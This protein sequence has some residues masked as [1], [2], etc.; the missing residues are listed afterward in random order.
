MG[1]YIHLGVEKRA[2]KLGIT[3]QEYSNALD[4]GIDPE[5]ALRADMNLKR[6]TA[7]AERLNLNLSEV[8]NAPDPDKFLEEVVKKNIPNRP[9]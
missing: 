9:N 6:W 8:L 5:R 2:E 7:E 4:S 1:E 3:P